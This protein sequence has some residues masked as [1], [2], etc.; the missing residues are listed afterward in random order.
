MAPPELDL[1][2]P[3]FFADPYPTYQ[4]LRD[5]APCHQV[6][7]GTWVLSRY[8]D[9]ARAL[10]DHETFSSSPMNMGA[11]GFK[12]LIGSDPPDHTQLRRLVNRPFHPAAIAQL[13]PRIRV[14]CTELID[15]LAAAAGRG[16]ADLVE[17]V[18][19]PLPV[20]VIAE[21][22]GI[23]IERRADFKRW[24]DAMI[25]G[26]DAGGD[27]SHRGTAAMEMF[28]YFN[29]VI[30]ERR[31]APGDDLISLLVGG[32]EPLS[33]QELLMFCM[34]LLVA[35][36]ETTTNL[37]SN[38]AMAL[39]DRPDAVARL[40][41]EPAL[42]PG[43]IEEALRYDA[44]VQSLMRRVVQE[45]EV[46]GRTLRPGATVVVLYGAANR[47][48]RHYERAE[49]FVV[50]RYAGVRGVAD[51]V[52]FGAGIHYCV[53]APLARLEARVA[54]EELFRRTRGMRPAGAGRRTSSLLVRGMT[55]LPV[56]FEPAEA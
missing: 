19:Y 14:I 28:A 13:E 43:A 24:S 36:N 27:Q 33:N 7:G 37:I 9:V 10:R 52:G 25:G 6:A 54:A 21:L 22:L 44:P 42:L 11:P 47:D 23:P 53:G 5:E 55:S 38:G 18:A 16:E 46:G 12:F 1:A 48:E 34:L 3:A 26:L 35:G 56:T 51:H 39:F 31:T 8:D 32:A 49:D 41:D 17:Q 2:S 40:R 20:I 50:D 4:R 45:V 15:D 30:A 29:D